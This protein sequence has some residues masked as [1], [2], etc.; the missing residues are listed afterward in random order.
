MKPGLILAA[1]ATSAAMLGAVSASAQPAPV[2][3]SNTL[4]LRINNA[5]VHQTMAGFGASDAWRM[6]MIGKHWPEAKKNQI[7]DLLFGSKISKDGRPE[8][9][10]LSLWRFYIGS[11]SMEQGTNS[12]IADEWRRA[13]CF[14]NP[15][16]TYDWSK[17]AGQRWFLQAAK[18]ET[19]AAYVTSATRNL[20]R[21]P[22]E[23]EG[24][25]I[26]ARSV[27]TVVFHPA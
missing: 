8:G 20:E 18:R 6:Q 7:A 19:L 25:L 4:T 1:W 26:P 14:Q 9:I 16:G 12:G 5:R 17:Q 23:R 22:A 2:A 27:V 10:G 13:E 15:D 21:Q 3:A 11:G 24:V